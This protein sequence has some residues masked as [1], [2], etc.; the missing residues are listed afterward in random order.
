MPTAAQMI[1]EYP[2]LLQ[3]V[4]ALEAQLAWFQKNPGDADCHL[5][6]GDTPPDRRLAPPEVAALAVTINTLMNHDA[7]VVKR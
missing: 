2:L 4:A 1:T 6:I 5:E 7:F 3:R